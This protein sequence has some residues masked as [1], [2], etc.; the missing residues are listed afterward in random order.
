ME[1]DACERLYPQ[2]GEAMLTFLPNS[3]TAEYVRSPWKLWGFVWGASGAVRKKDL[4]VSRAFL[5]YFSRRSDAAHINLGQVISA[6]GRF[7]FV[8]SIDVDASYSFLK[9]I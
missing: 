6:E 4:A 3:G 1:P 8:I 5:N 9:G 7:C 2:I